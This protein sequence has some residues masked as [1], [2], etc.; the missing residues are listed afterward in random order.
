MMDAPLF[1]VLAPVLVAAFVAAA[2]P[3]PATLAIAREAMAHGR[4]A[5]LLLAL[6]VATGSWTWS[7]LA[8]GGMSA[9]MLAHGWTLDAMRVL[10]A[11]YLG[12]LAWKSGKAAMTP[13]H[14][15]MDVAPPPAGR[16]YLRGLMI[17]LT[18]PKAILFFGALYSVGLPADASTMT[19]FIIAAAVGIQSTLVFACLALLFSHSRIVKAYGRLRRGFEAAFATVFG[20]ASVGF[21]ISI[22]RRAF[23]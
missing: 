18:N 6:G 12:W 15:A 10:A 9:L 14:D 7:A 1:L 2:S 3:G 13:K 8:A 11:G 23:A 16:S 5:G 17:H 21:V 20:L 19:V 22:W 4:R